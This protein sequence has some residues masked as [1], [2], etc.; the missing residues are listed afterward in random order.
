[1]ARSSFTQV[2]M[3]ALALLAVTVLGACTEQDKGLPSL[4]GSASPTRVTEAEGLEDVA[5]N[6]YNCMRDAGIEVELAQNDDGDL[7]V[8]NYSGNHSF[9]QC[10]KTFCTFGATGNAPR[11][12]DEAT[13]EFVLDHAADTIL[14]IDGVDHSEAFAG[15]LSSTGYDEQ[16]ALRGHSQVNPAEVERQ[17]R[18]N[19]LWAACARENGWPGIKD[20]AMESDEWP[21]VLLPTTITEDQLRQLL[22]A[23]PNFD[24]EEQKRMDDWWADNPMATEWPDDFLPMPIIDFEGVKRVG[25]LSPEDEAVLAGLEPLYAILNEESNAYAEGLKTGPR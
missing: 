10:E 6:Y 3:T 15:C 5:W 23:C 14:V 13:A 18:S 8:V 7:A 24:S 17:V 19:N 11:P 16:V 20:S 2:S 12:P 4:T 9:M 21:T 25:T 1:M 22:D